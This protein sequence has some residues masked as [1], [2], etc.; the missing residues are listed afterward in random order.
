[1]FDL[2][3]IF[4]RINSYL[5]EK[6]CVTGPVRIAIRQQLNEFIVFHVNIIALV[7]FISRNFEF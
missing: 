3:S 2:K 6:G 7:T 1:M 4:E 5:V